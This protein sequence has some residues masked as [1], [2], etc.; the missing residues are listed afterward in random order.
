M[1]RVVGATGLLFAIVLTVG[2]CG[3]GGGD[4]SPS[5]EKE[6]STTDTAGSPRTL[7]E[8]G[9]LAAGEYRTEKF[10]PAFS[11]EVGTGWSMGGPEFEEALFIA[12]GEDGFLTFSNPKKVFDAKNPVEQREIPAPDTVEGW[13]AWHQKNP[14]LEVSDIERGSASVDGA[15]GTSFHLEAAS[16]PEKATEICGV[17]CVPGFPV[18]STAYD[19]FLSDEERDMVLEVGEDVVI[20]SVAA[21]KGRL[22]EFRPEAQKVLNTVEWKDSS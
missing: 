13:V 5:A 2:A 20:I 22:D 10:E 21:P 15:T 19:F 16:A 11:F 4:Q 14:Y 18:G 3:G 8:V 12:Q 6:P 1:K 9:D 17:P 7:P